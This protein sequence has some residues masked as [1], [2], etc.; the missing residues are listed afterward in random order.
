MQSSRHCT[1]VATHTHTTM[2][3]LCTLSAK[4]GLLRKSRGREVL[5]GWRKVPR[6]SRYSQRQPVLGR[7]DHI[8]EEH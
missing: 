6:F 8:K 7:A 2:A 5:I 3:V 4:L 1:A